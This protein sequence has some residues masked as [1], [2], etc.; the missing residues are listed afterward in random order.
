MKK[1][2]GS[3]SKGVPPPP[4]GFDEEQKSAWGFLPWRSIFLAQ[5]SSI[6][7]TLFFN[8][9]KVNVP[10]ISIA[11]IAALLL[12]YVPSYYFHSVSPFSITSNSL[13]TLGIAILYASIAILTIM[14]AFLTFWFGS[15]KDAM[16]K[17]Q[18]R[19]RDELRNL[20]VIKQDISP[21]LAGPKEG[22]PTDIK[23]KVENLAKK[24]DTFYKSLSRF[25]GRFSRASVGTYYDAVELAGLQHSVTAT[26]G[27]WF[28]AHAKTFETLDERA[29]CRKTWENAMHSSGQLLSLNDGA[30]HAHNQMMQIINFMPTL[31]SILFVFLVSL[32][33]VFVSSTSNLQPLVGLILGFILVILLPIHVVNMVR[34]LWKQLFLEFVTHE[35]NR[36]VDTQQ[37]HT[38]EQRH[39]V[40]DKE[41]IMKDLKVLIDAYTEKEQ[42]TNLK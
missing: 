13:S 16:R 34:F 8:W 9:V 24:A 11:T 15:A 41:A 3:G 19:T 14:F 42:D 37:S 38:I 25:V 32:V 12:H 7:K 1:E 6:K 26:G 4:N 5:R 31:S 35:T 29:F 36:L 30:N 27:E 28:V 22:V 17:I 20:E 21:F 10:A 2:S 18:D 33:I 23:E 40:D 39:P